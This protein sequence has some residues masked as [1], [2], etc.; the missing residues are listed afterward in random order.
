MYSFDETDAELKE[1]RVNAAE[2][3]AGSKVPY[4]AA[5]L[6]AIQDRPRLK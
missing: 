3:R 6:R 2:Q 5:R 1:K 4:A